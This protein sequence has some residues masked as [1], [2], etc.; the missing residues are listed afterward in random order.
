MVYPTL[1]GNVSMDEENIDRLRQI[2][3]EGG[4]GK[5][6]MKR[7][8]GEGKHGSCM[9][10]PVPPSQRKGSNFTCACGYTS[11]HPIPIEAS[12]SYLANFLAD[13][14]LSDL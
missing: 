4:G 12:C 10:H 14:K 8:R 7:V 6:M 1:L 5:K 13:P 3:E 9:P 11:F 2:W